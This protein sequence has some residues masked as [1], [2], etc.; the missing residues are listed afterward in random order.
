MARSIYGA[1][2]YFLGFSFIFMPKLIKDTIK[3]KK[4]QELTV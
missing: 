1:P 2:L 4:E 3:L